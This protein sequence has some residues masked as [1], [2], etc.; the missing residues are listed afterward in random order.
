MISLPSRTGL[1]LALLIGLGLVGLAVY[2]TGHDKVFRSAALDLTF[3]R[4][5]A[6]EQTKALLASQGH[7]LTSAEESAAFFVRDAAII[8]FE[9]KA[10]TEQTNDWLRNDDLPVWG[11]D[12]RF[13][14]PLKKEQFHVWWSP[15]GKLFGYRHDLLRE[16]KRPSISQR[17]ALK[18]AETESKKHPLFDRTQ[19][20]LV[21][22]SSDRKTNRTDHTFRWRSNQNHLSSRIY[23]KATVSGNRVSSFQR[24]VQIPETFTRSETEISSRRRLL[25]LFAN[26]IDWLLS[27][28]IFVF[29]I[30]AWRKRWVRF[31]PALILV[32][33]V[34]LVQFASFFNGTPL[35]WHHYPT[36]QETSAF[37]L[38]QIALGSLAILGA[39][40]W[41]I[42]P[43]SSSDAM[44]RSLAGSTYSLGELTRAS[45]Y[46]SKSFLQASLAGFGAA[47][48]HLGFV[49]LF[50]YIG[51][52][53]FN[54][55]APLDIPYSDLLTSTIPWIQPLLV[56]LSAAL[57][58]ET[59]YRLFA[60]PLL[61]RW[62]RRKW[63]ALLLPALLWGFLHTGYYVEPIYARGLELTLVGL[64]YGAVFLRFGIWATI[65]SHYTYNAVVSSSVLWG[66]NEPHLWLPLA[67]V[68]GALALPIF[69]N[70][71]HLLRKRTF[72]K[73]KLPP[74]PEGLAPDRSWLGRDRRRA[75]KREARLPLTPPV[76]VT[77]GLLMMFILLPWGNPVPKMNLDRQ[78]ATE[79]AR[80]HLHELGYRV[81][82]HLTSASLSKAGR[83]LAAEYVSDQ[84]TPEQAP[85]YLD[86][87]QPRKLRWSV[88]FVAP[89]N[90]D[91]CMVQVDAEGALDSFRCKWGEE[92]PGERL[93][94]KTSRE[95]AER[96]L[97]SHG[98]KAKDLEYVLG[99][100]HDRPARMDFTHRWSDPDATVSDLRR[101]IDVRVSSDQISSFRT[102][103]QV[104]E[105]YLRSEKQQSLWDVIRTIVFAI[106]GFLLAAL[107]IRGLFDR[108]VTRNLLARLPARVA[109]V[110][111][112]LYLLG[113]FNSLPHFWG[114]Y[115]STS[116][117]EVFFGQKL[118][119]TFGHTLS[120]ALV[121][122]VA[123]LLFLR[124]SPQV[125]PTAPTEEDMR[126]VSGRF[127]W[128]WRGS[129]VAF[130]WALALLMTQIFVR[131]LFDYFSGDPLHD[132]I[133]IDIAAFSNAFPIL[134]ILS[135]AWTGVLFWICF[136]A[137]VSACIK[138]LK[139]ALSTFALV[140]LVWTASLTQSGP[141]DQMIP[142]LLN[143]L[144][145]VWVVVRHVRFHLPFYVWYAFLSASIPFLPWLLAGHRFY[146]LH[147]FFVAAILFLVA[148][149]LFRPPP[150]PS[151]SPPTKGT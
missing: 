134:T 103:L 146:Q 49:V 59:V 79:H 4:T 73:L 145:T 86:Q 20:E 108:E 33:A 18:I 91:E 83:G 65:V 45:F 21:E 16:T 63:I 85:S 19:F 113:W 25:S 22:R 78:E 41:R 46:Q 77:M 140:L 38:H 43:F 28:A 48:V 36:N 111:A 62:T 71:F 147:S 29:L 27:L 127:P 24:E 104:P 51:R 56:G 23:L 118:L 122:Y 101:Y 55:Y 82:H 131:H 9:K 3:S 144:L 80:I 14:W 12:V 135:S 119:V 132:P 81:D 50:Y 106:S 129:R 15:H 117:I 136:A 137:V 6:I 40:A 68:I 44:G 114:G 124:L 89:G 143:F 92:T 11:W 2:V 102:Y 139:P 112:G 126:I 93:T 72:R 84:L 61:L 54:L 32:G 90:V 133:G 34:T 64:F 116:S 138:Y 7:D 121:A 123:T 67:F 100:E 17:K 95:R 109:L 125:F 57:Q 39:M 94:N 141:S 70:L 1:F 130:L 69:P 105:S 26:R 58:E 110:S 98:I 87:Y 148:L 75:S 88:R 120:T 60:I 47:G 31:K 52:T 149:T 115:H 66:S 142:H 96:F 53:T 5:E 97:A 76:A 37:W 30:Q 151:P 128:R 13:F 99:K 42:F 35:L 150:R 74:L 107:I 10:G 8:Y